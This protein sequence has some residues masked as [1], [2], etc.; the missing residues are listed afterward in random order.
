[1]LSLNLFLSRTNQRCWNISSNSF[2]LFRR[3]G[4]NNYRTSILCVF[5][6]L[7]KIVKL[8]IVIVSIFMI[9]SVIMSRSH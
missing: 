2:R 4:I 1:M 5:V 8:N 9:N 7:Y 6:I 3:R